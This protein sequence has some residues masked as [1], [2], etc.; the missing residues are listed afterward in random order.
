MAT[1]DVGYISDEGFFIL[2]AKDMILAVVRTFIPVIEACLLIKYIEA[3][4]V[5]IEHPIG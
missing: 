3:A 2:V 5:G 1:G 4:V